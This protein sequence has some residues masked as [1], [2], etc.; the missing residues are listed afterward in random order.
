[1]L[2]DWDLETFCVCEQDE[3]ILR[4]KEWEGTTQEAH[5]SDNTFNTDFPLFHEP[6]KTNKD[7]ELSSRIQN[8]LGNYDE[9]R[10]FLTDQLNQSHLTGIPKNKI[11]QVPAEKLEQDSFFYSGNITQ[12]LQPNNSS[13]DSVFPSSFSTALIPYSPGRKNL[14]KDWPQNEHDSA[15]GSNIECDG[16]LA[17]NKCGDSRNKVNDSYSSLN[18]HKIEH[19]TNMENPEKRQSPRPK[20]LHFGHQSFLKS[21]SRNYPNR[22]HRNSKLSWKASVCSFAQETQSSSVL[23]KH[24]NNELYAQNLPPSLSSKPNASQQKPTAYVRPMDGQDQAPNESP[25]LKQSVEADISYGN[26]TYRGLP[27]VKNDVPGFKTMK[28]KLTIPLSKEVMVNGSSKNNQSV[29]EILQEMTHSWP[30]PLT[31]IHT[32]SKGE[33]SILLIPAKNSLKQLW[34]QRFQLQAAAAGQ[35]LQHPRLARQE[36]EIPIQQLKLIVLQYK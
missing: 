7:D 23:T 21:L 10:D 26:Q 33:T 6:Y 36:S 18:E 4:G 5:Q 15:S 20:S 25:V 3:N 2:E 13:T 32:P 1:M 31:A 28:E 11:W 35:K 22:C 27:D 19:Q 14:V 12:N 30:P 34:S 24:T 17:K 16:Q 8:T 9:M 29:E